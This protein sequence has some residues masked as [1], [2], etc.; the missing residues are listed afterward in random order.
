MYYGLRLQR[1]GKGDGRE[2]EAGGGYNREL[3]R[4]HSPGESEGFSGLGMMMVIR[5]MISKM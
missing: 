1:R 4:P 5:G 2:G 3:K